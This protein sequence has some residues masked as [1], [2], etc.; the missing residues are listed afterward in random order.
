MN[1]KKALAAVALLA[2]LAFGAFQAYLYS[3]GLYASAPVYQTGNGAIDGYDPV[4][5]FNA[6]QPQR[7]QAR[8][9][10]TWNGAV[11]SFASAANQATFRAE[12]ER[13]A[14]QFGGYCAYAV[15]NGYTAKADPTA[16]HIEDGRLYLNFDASVKADWRQR[17]GELI[18]AGQ[19]NWPRVIED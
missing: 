3:L 11:W 6:G 10:E 17:R 13:Y 15:A 8:F 19:R 18:A 5:Y 4:A 9:R 14:P 7:G 2:V 12:P 1:W 16:W